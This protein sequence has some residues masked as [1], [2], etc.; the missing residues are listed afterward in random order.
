MPGPIADMSGEYVA[1]QTAEA[2]AVDDVKA[3]A[4]LQ[5]NRDHEAQDGGKRVSA[6]RRDG[7]EMNARVPAGFDPV[8][9]DMHLVVFSEPRR[10]FRHIAAMPTS[11]MIVMDDKGD[12]QWPRILP[13]G[14]FQ[15]RGS[16]IF[17]KPEE[18]RRSFGRNSYPAQFQPLVPA[19]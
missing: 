7:V 16:R 4:N 15:E 12:F 19:P 17:S 6:P 8:R 14:G 9:K 2:L 13:A 1:A 3:P 11:A 10:K 5:A 18:Y